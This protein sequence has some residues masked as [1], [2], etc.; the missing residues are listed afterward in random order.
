MVLLA[1]GL[2]GTMLAWRTRVP[3]MLG[4]VMGMT[5][6]NR[7]LPLPAG[8]GVLD[9]MHRARIL[10]DLP[11]SVADV[12]GDDEVRRI[13]FTSYADARKLEKG[14]KYTSA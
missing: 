4:Y 14:R 8:C 7:Y 11:V 10:W 13:A 3:D 1:T 2:A 5:N 12:G 9:A 6:N